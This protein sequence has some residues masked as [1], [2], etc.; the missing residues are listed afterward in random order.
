M[1]GHSATIATLTSAEILRLKGNPE[2][3][4]EIRDYREHLRRRS[5]QNE[6]NSGRK[7]Y[8]SYQRG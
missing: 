5:Y 8:E 6:R 7:N 1:T 2:G 3:S 4:F